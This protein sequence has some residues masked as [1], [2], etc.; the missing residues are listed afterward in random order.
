MSAR[1]FGVTFDPHIGYHIKS[2]NS[3]GA[4]IYKCMGTYTSYG[5]Y[6]IS[7]MAIFHLNVLG[8][9]WNQKKKKI[10]VIYVVIVCRAC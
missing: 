9:H 5:A 1:G 2:L 10:N 4:Y 8:K 7:S 3:T 6:E